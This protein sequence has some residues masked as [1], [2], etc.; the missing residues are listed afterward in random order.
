MPQIR[1]KLVLLIAGILAFFTSYS[2]SADYFK[3]KIEYIYYSDTL[4]DIFRIDSIARTD[5]FKILYPS[6]RIKEFSERCYRIGDYAFVG[7]KIK[8]DNA[9]NYYF[10]NRYAKP[11][12]IK[13]N[14]KINEKWTAYKFENGNE[15]SANIQSIDTFTLFQNADT[16]TTIKFELA[17]SIGNVLQNDYCADLKVSKNFGFY[18]ILNFRDFPDSLKTYTLFDNSEINSDTSKLTAVQI[19]NYDVGDEFHTEE[20][21]G[22]WFGTDYVKTFKILK[23]LSKR[24]SINNDTLDFEVLTC[25]K[26]TIKNNPKYWYYYHHKTEPLRI[27][28]SEYESYDYTVNELYL[29]KYGYE[30]E[31]SQQFVDEKTHLRAKSVNIKLYNS[32]WHGCLSEVILDKRKSML[33]E[34][35]QGMYLEGVIG[36]DDYYKNF[37]EEYRKLLY[38]KKGDKI[39]GTPLNCDSLLTTIPKIDENV[40]EIYP[41]PATNCININNLQ[42][43]SIIQV[44]NLSGIELLTMPTED[45]NES[46]DITSLSSGIY[47]LKIQNKTSLSVFRFVKE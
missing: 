14:T 31:S 22:N 8:I 2:Q 7:E 32:E 30:Y 42:P 43:N 47:I 24:I 35:G 33:L 20:Y 45:A 15:I 38:Y 23:I 27:V 13:A 10:Y 46:I 36:Y 3:D 18:Q 6:H 26:E 19:F 11:I 5:S 21:S 9:G 44:Y 41:N 12:L 29:N 17:D 39:Y 34:I 28:L 25:M 16:L 40:L 1:K 4:K 37:T